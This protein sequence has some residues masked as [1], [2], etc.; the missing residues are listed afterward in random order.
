[1]VEFSEDTNHLI[2]ELQKF[3]D[4]KI[5][6]VKAM[7]FIV[8]I[9]SANIQNPELEDI[10][11]LSKYINGLGKVMHKIKYQ[12][13]NDASAENS[14]GFIKKEFTENLNKLFEL[15]LKYIE[16]S[17]SDYTEKFRTKYLQLNQQSLINITSLIYDLSWLKVYK[18]Q[19]NK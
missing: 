10:L 5:K 19:I 15:I 8:E 12:I 11:F 3:S 7:S 6:N 9:S 16:D 2:S 17:N 4:S 18:T 14:F 13:N 1:M